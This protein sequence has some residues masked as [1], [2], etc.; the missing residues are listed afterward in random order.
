MTITE[1]PPVAEL[2]RARRRKEDARLITGQTNWTDNI[3]LPGMLHMAF[4][5]SP[6]AHAKITSVDVSAALSK[7][8]CR[9]PGR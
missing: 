8:A 4:V 5:R 3:T 7:A 2:G 9:A 6:F 1:E